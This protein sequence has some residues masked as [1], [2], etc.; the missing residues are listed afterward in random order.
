MLTDYWH[1]KPLMLF[2]D[3]RVRALQMRAKLRNVYH[4]INSAGWYRGPHRFGVIGVNDLEPVVIR[5]VYGEPARIEHCQDLELFVYRDEAA[6]RL[7]R[8]MARPFA[9]FTRH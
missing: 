4:W 5:R 8:D 7:S 2:S 9:R 3:Q 1:A 6:A